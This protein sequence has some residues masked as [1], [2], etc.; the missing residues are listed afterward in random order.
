MQPLVT[1]LNKTG[2]LRGCI[3]AKKKLVTCLASGENTLVGS[4]IESYTGV[5][6]IFHPAAGVSP[7]MLIFCQ[8]PVFPSH[9]VVERST[10]DDASSFGRALSL[11][12]ANQR[13]VVNS[14]HEKNKSLAHVLGDLRMAKGVLVGADKVQSSPASKYTRPCHVLRRR[15]ENVIYEAIR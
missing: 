14:L 1:I 15:R 7:S 9:A 5:S 8:K 4:V 10:I 11:E 13:F 3:A 6:C 2:R 12:M